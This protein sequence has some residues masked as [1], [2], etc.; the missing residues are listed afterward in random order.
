M[1]PGRLLLCA[2]LLLGACKSKQEKIHPVV[3]TITESVYAS[4]T[5][6]SRDQYQVFPTVNG[7]VQQIMVT[8]GDLVRKGDPIMRLSNEAVRLSRENAQLAAEYSSVGANSARLNELRINIDLARTRMQTDSALL[9]RQRNL[10]A[11]EIG[12]RNELDGREL[13]YKNSV[14]AYKAAILRYNDLQRQVEFGARQSLK[15]LQISNVQSGDY[16]IRSEAA[17]RVY[18]VLKEVGE[19]AGPQSPVAVI[20]AAG[21]FMIELQV[22]EYD[23]A[24]LRPGQKVVVSM[25]SYK[26]QVFEAV[27]EKINPLMNE[28]SRSF[29]VDAAF[30]TRPPELYPN[31]TVEANVVIRVKQ[32]ALTIPRNYLI[33]DTYVLTNQN[34][35]KKVV[36]GLKDY[37]RV[38]V[39]GGLT[40]D[41]VIQKPVP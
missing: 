6:K 29:T 28:R 38:E 2:T 27:V 37:Q 19:M 14:T 34:E 22:D 24:K 7:L 32:N 11:Q 30:T 39:V 23:I 36:T 35:K 20:G 10:W 31:L 17:G 13:A 33:D 26:G 18:S 9:G 41:D 5:V 16:I 4:G 1:N 21:S 40:K 8:E 25:D 12:T 15:N 3:Q